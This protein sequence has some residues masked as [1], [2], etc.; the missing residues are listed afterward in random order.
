MKSYANT[1]KKSKG[2]NT[3][4]NTPIQ[5]WW[6]F[7]KKDKK[8]TTRAEQHI[9][10]KH[11]HSSKKT[12][13]PALTEDDFL[14][15]TTPDLEEDD[16]EK[17]EYPEEEITHEKTGS[18]YEELN[19]QSFVHISDEE[20]N[21]LKEEP[22]ETEYDLFPN[23]TN[24]P[25]HFEHEMDV[26]NGEELKSA[27]ETEFDT[28]Y[29]TLLY[30]FFHQPLFT[31]KALNSPSEFFKRVEYALSVYEK[32]CIVISKDTQLQ[33][34]RPFAG[35]ISIK[36]ISKHIVPRFINDDNKILRPKIEKILIDCHI[37]FHQSEGE[38]KSVKNKTI[39]PFSITSHTTEEP[40]P[41]R[42][43]DLFTES[44][45]DSFLE[46]TKPTVEDTPK[47]VAVKPKLTIPEKLPI[48]PSSNTPTKPTVEDKPKPVAVKPKLTIPEKLPIIPSSNNPT[49]PT[50]NKG[51]NPIFFSPLT[52]YQD[53][54]WTMARTNLPKYFNKPT[55]A[56][57]KK[58]TSRIPKPNT[59]VKTISNVGNDKQEPNDTLGFMEMISYSENTIRK[60]FNIPSDKQ[61]KS[62]LID[63][64]KVK[65]EPH[66]WISVG[67]YLAKSANKHP[68]NDVHLKTKE[69]FTRL[70]SNETV[71]SHKCKNIITKFYTM[72]GSIN[73]HEISKY[74]YNRINEKSTGV[75]INKGIESTNA[76]TTV[77]ETSKN[78]SK[79]TD[80]KTTATDQTHQPLSKPT[81]TY[82]VADKYMCFDK[83]TNKFKWC[84]KPSDDE[85]IHRLKTNHLTWKE[86]QQILKAIKKANKKFKII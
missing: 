28:A 44:S 23:S 55:P 30:T 16:F 72:N 77:T 19:S 56:S 29:H 12:R 57:P 62:K 27:K 36:E 82:A 10:D 35:K 76:K 2:I 48:I 66:F 67:I 61:L 4:E 39:P 47:L 83:E 17:I 31:D 68:S 73:I 15:I 69:L 43:E 18:D 46:R 54:F 20:F 33:Q 63:E 11:S 7:N 8:A 74:L 75:W 52:K 9:L 3:P 22:F 49:K 59:N 81:K 64:H 85:D 79:E 34:E 21:N 5:R 84:E 80:V 25:V 45:S 58:N 60:L 51:F 32:N 14:K 53:V 86:E 50:T 40:T 65:V 42:H 71:F 41:P 26:I 78:L 38:D 70:A 24:T 37:P 6:P 1:S 13:N